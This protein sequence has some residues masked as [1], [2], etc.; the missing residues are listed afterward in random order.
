MAKNAPDGSIINHFERPVLIKKPPA[1][2]RR[3]I[4]KA[5]LQQ[6]FISKAGGGTRIAHPLR[7]PTNILLRI[8]K[9]CFAATFYLER[10]MG[11]EPT[12]ISLE[13]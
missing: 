10:A 7:V 11:L 13:G 9:G 6:P 3:G 2:I 8:K 5:T 4:K 1:N 12:N